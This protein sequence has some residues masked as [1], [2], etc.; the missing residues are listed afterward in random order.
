M[1]LARATSSPTRQGYRSTKSQRNPL[2]QRFTR[3]AEGDS[4]V[5]RREGAATA[6]PSF[7]RTASATARAVMPKAS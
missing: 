7:W 5:P 1:P 6:Q 2:P 3:T 4:G